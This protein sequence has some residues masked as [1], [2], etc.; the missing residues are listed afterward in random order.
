[1]ECLGLFKFDGRELCNC[2]LTSHDILLYLSHSQVVT[3]HTFNRPSEKDMSENMKPHGAT[4]Q[5][6]LH[7][8]VIGSS[9][10]LEKRILVI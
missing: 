2:R 4:V 9:S 3:P 7:K 6:C 1:M 8:S 5:A 10:Q